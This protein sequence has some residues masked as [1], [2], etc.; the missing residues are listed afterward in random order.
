MCI[1]CLIECVPI[2]WSLR[3]TQRWDTHRV[4]VPSKERKVYAVPGV[5]SG[6]PAVP[7]AAEGGSRAPQE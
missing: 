5:I 2:Y 1:S 3:L 6:A 7:V 4:T